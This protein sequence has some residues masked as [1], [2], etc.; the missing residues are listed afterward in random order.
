MTKNPPLLAIVLCGLLTACGG[1]GAGDTHDDPVI[2]SQLNSSNMMDA[3][4]LSLRAQSTVQ[5]LNQLFRLASRE[6]LTELPEKPAGACSGGGSYS[7]TRTAQQH[8]LQLQQCQLANYRYRKGTLTSEESS[9]STSLTLT[10]VGFDMPQADLSFDVAGVVTETLSDAKQWRWVG[11]VK[12]ASVAHTD[13]WKYTLQ[14][15]AAGT[16]APTGE[17]SLQSSRIK[18]PLTVRWKTGTPSLVV[19]APDG[20]SVSIIG[21]E[22][23]QLVAQLRASNG[24]TSQRNITDTELRTAMG[25]WPY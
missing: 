17:L 9:A 15:P 8:R 23:S 16:E 25:A 14:S 18:T 12:I 24:A 20:S 6:V 7:Y 10:D 22:G 21:A 3:V 2:P 19:Q 4:A 5:V 13:T 11:D 1:G